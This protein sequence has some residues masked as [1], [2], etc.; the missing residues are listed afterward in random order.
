MRVRQIDSEI[1]NYLAGECTPSESLRIAALIQSDEAYKH[2]YNQL[3]QLWD[4]PQAIPVSDTY[5]TDAAWEQ[6]KTHI[7]EHSLK[8]AYQKPVRQLL[9]GT[10]L[11][12]VSGIAAILLIS[13]G[14]YFFNTSG[15]VHLNTL[16]SGSQI[17][18]PVALS[19]GSNISLYKSSELKFPDKFG[20]TSREV[21]FWG[22]AFFEIASDPTRP[23]VIESGDARI[24][25]LGTSFNVKSI[26]AS[27]I[28]EV[29][30]HTG[31]V[32]FYHV[33]AN[34]TVLNQVVL[35]KGEKGI[36]NHKLRT[37]SRLQNN[38]PN[39]ISWK[40]GVLVFNETSLD[41]VMETIGKR[42]DVSFHWSDKQLSNLKLTAT[43]DNESLDAVLEVLTLVHKL[44]FS[45]NGKDFLV[46]KIAG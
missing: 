16:A 2:S 4:A 25:V 37:I 24:K 10:W 29:V 44:K 41:K 30:V 35:T 11:K 46:S 15:K 8:L 43:F 18:M 3:K 26:P 45:N 14:I 38:D 36:Y 21:Y 23:F 7:Q 32:L 13:F 28:T 9:S 5:N 19:D 1:V 27:D 17:D 12:Y 33:D 6:V 34:N 20:K 42:Y 40:T 39:F 22:E 31:K